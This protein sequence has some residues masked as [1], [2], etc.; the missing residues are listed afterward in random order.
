MRVSSLPVAECSGVK[1][2]S[3]AVE[4]LLGKGRLHEIDHPMRRARN[5]STSTGSEKLNT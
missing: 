1:V 5:F 4:N 2:S 3:L